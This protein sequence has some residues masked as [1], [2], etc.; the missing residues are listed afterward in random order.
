MK[1]NV[2]WLSAVLLAFLAA[3]HA[4]AQEPRL[5]KVVLVGDSIRLG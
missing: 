1:F 4:S 5:P 3:L 2:N